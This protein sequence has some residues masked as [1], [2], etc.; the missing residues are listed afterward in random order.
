VISAVL[1]IFA[2]IDVPICYMSI[3]W[4][5][6]Q[7]PSPVFGDGGNI[8]PVMKYAYLWNVLAWAMWGAFILGMRYAIERR[9]QRQANAHSLGFL[10]EEPALQEVR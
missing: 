4:W 2:A 6:T 10:S 9:R 1:A 8:D 7:H 5:R 3:R